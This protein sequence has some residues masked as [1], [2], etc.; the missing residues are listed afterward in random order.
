MKEPGPLIIQP[1]QD[2]F[3]GERK[4]ARE[5]RRKAALKTHPIRKIADKAL[6]DK[7]WAFRNLLWIRTKDKKLVPF[8]AYPVQKKFIQRINKKDRLLSRDILLKYRQGGFSTAIT[9]DLFLDTHFTPNVTTLSITQDDDTAINFFEIIQRYYDNMPEKLQFPLA[10][11]N[12][13]EM[14]YASTDSKYIVYS[15]RKGMSGLGK[16]SSLGRSFTVNNL[17]VTEAAFIA[18]FDSLRQGLFQAVSMQ[19]GRIIIESTPNGPAGWFYEEIMRCLEKDSNFA[20]HFY[21]WWD[22]P[23]YRIPLSEEDWDTVYET[24]TDVEA[25]LVERFD[26]DAEQV[27]WRRMKIKDLGGGRK[28]EQDF[29]QEYPEDDMSCWIVRERNVFDPDRLTTF[30]EPNTKR[31]PIATETYRGGQIIY[32][33][34]PVEGENYVLGGDTAEGDP[35]NDYSCGQVIGEDEFTQCAVIHGHY[36]PKNFAY[37]CARVGRVYNNAMLAIE[38]NNHG[39]SCINTLQNQIYYPNVYH[40]MEYDD[41]AGKKVLKPG[42]PTTVKTRPIMISETVESVDGCEFEIQD[43]MTLSEA[44]TFIWE[45]D[46]PMALGKNEG[47]NKDDRIIALCIAVYVRNRYTMAAVLDEI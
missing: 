44:R 42:F 15:A 37:A 13:R 4:K 39:H 32:Y 19:G 28:G 24:L 20:Y 1:E 18:N 8:N 12:V 26:I 11:S 23:Y 29:L 40:H 3:L 31:Q 16:S 33:E 41:K 7:D 9:A 45:G 46:K 35:G 6:A 47:H 14:K 30:H 43:K 5:E 2:D 25:E 36:T 21:R 17:H 38:R 27:A 10:R 22:D 34:D